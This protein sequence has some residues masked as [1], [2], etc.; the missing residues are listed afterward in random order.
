PVGKRDG[1]IFGVDVSSHQDG[2]SLKRAASEGID[3]AIIRTTDGTYKDRCY[4]SHLDDAESAGL[5][6]A[7]YHYLRN[8]SEGTTVTQQVQAAL[9]VMGDAKRPMWLDCETPAGLH[10]DHIREAKREFERHGVRVI[11]AYSYVP[12]WEGSIAPGEPDSHEFG[13]FWVAAYGSNRTGTPA[14]IYPGDSASQWD[15]PLGNQKPAL[16]Q[17][18]SNAQVAGYNV[19][20]NA[21]R[22]SRDELRALFYGGKQHHEGEEMTTKFFTDFLTGYLGPQIKAIQEI[23]TQL[24]GPGGKGWEQLGQNAQ[25]Q[26][27]TPVDALAAIRQ[28]L[29]QIQADVNEIKRGKK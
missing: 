10:V 16:W 24:R 14:N 28:Q 17:Y 25:G 23:W 27:L 5:I 26:N 4:R 9:E 29:A 6:T 3:F 19:D 2:M 11:G 12:Y 21:Y 8:P 15:Y 13:A 18:G 22:G 7:A 1:T 20:I